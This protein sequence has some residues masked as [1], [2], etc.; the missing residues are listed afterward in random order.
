MGHLDRSSLTLLDLRLPG[1]PDDPRFRL[2]EGDISD[3]A[4]L[5]LGLNGRTDIVLHLA[6]GLGW[7]AEADHSLGRRI[8]VDATLDLLEALRDPQP[9]PRLVFARS[10]AWPA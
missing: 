1:A 7:A 6:G 2:I 9:P 10:I 8:N 5:A 3:P 4:V